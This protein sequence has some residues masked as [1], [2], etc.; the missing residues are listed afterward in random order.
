[1]IPAKFLPFPP[2]KGT[3]MP[4][5]ALFIDRWGTLL[6]PT[7]RGPARNPDQVTF[8][9]GAAD[10]L[11]RA[12]RAGWTIYLLGNEDQ[13]ARGQQ[14]Q[15]S[16]LAVEEAILEGLRSMG[17]AVAGSYA[18]LDDPEHGRG[19][20]RRE[21]VFRL[22]NTGAFYH[23]AH[24]DGIDLRRSWVIGDSSLELAAGW[25]SG[26]QTAGVRTG[27]ALQDGHLALDPDLLVADLAAAVNNILTGI[28]LRVA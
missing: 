22:P 5:A 23:A 1:M 21:S 26:C 9:P 4:P 24:V 17:V 15:K 12:S 20:R 27:Q 6:Q 3:G 25:R 18:C 13:V 7:Q 28:P 16:W 19:K 11:F 8:L 14:S 10:A 2:L